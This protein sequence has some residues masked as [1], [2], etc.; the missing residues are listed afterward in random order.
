MTLPVMWIVNWLRLSAVAEC[1]LM[2]GLSRLDD[3]RQDTFLI[4]TRGLQ[5]VGA[6]ISCS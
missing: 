1:T 6:D 5:V 4:Q 2:M 3:S